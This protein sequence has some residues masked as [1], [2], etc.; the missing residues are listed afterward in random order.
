[1]KHKKYPKG[2]NLKQLIYTSRSV[3]GVD[4]DKLMEILTISKSSNIEKGISGL[5]VFDGAYFL[6]CLEGEAD[7]VD[8]I[9][10]KVIRDKRH[11][12]VTILGEQIIKY[13]EFRTWN[14][15]FLNRTDKLK[16]IILKSTGQTT[17]DPYALHYLKVKRLLLELAIVI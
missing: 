13:R 16:E 6:A 12:D 1:M 8:G 7:A 15:S 11:T 4:T 14:M 17:F 3:D 2:N 5:L 9:F 10:S